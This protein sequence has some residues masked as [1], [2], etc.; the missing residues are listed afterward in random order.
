M[1]H[2]RFQQ[3]RTSDT[4][5]ILWVSADPGSGKSVLAKHLIDNVLPHGI[6]GSVICYFFFKDDFEDQRSAKSAIS[7]ILHQL[8]SERDDLFSDDVLD[9]FNNG[10]GY[11]NR[12]LHDLWDILVMALSQNHQS[13]KRSRDVICVVDGFDECESKGQSELAKILCNFYGGHADGAT[14][15]E[16][17][18]RLKF[19]ITSRPYDSIR[20]ILQPLLGNS[21]QRLIHLAGEGEVE[22]T[23]IAAEIVLFIRARIEQLTVLHRLSLDEKKL[24]LD[25]ILCVPNRT[26]LWVYLT[27]DLI[28]RNFHENM[29]LSSV[30]LHLP[31]TVDSAYERILAK[32]TDRATTKKLLHI[33]VAA[34]RPLTLKEMNVALAIRQDSK[35]YDGIRVVPEARFREYIRNLCGLFVTIIDSKIYLL[36]QT[37]KEFLVGSD[38][39][40]TIS[41]CIDANNNESPWKSSLQPQ[42]SHHVLLRIAIWYLCLPTLEDDTLSLQSK[43]HPFK[44]TESPFTRSCLTTVFPGYQKYDFEF[45]RY[46]ALRWLVH[47]YLSKRE[48]D[49]EYVPLLLHKNGPNSKYNAMWF[50]VYFSKHDYATAERFTNLAIVSYLGL[51]HFVQTE[52]EKS[53]VDVNATD[54]YYG[55]SALSWAS[56]RGHVDVVKLLLQLSQ[57]AQKTTRDN[58]KIVDINLKDGL[59]QTP[60]SL[61]AESGREEVMKLLLHA[62]ADV[63]VLDWIGET[64][65]SLSTTN[66]DVDIVRLLQQSGASDVQSDVQSEERYRASFKTA[67][68]WMTRRQKGWGK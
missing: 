42:D 52:F 28:E 37:A 4:S 67:I 34:M 26:Y 22:T 8:F 23:S 54:T 14:S 68:D 13:P 11:E 62:G 19:L 64:A 32:S 61:A 53:D 65:L 63:D 20:K 51:T 48:T 2:T 21:G 60:L 45:F 46:C 18:F 33:V 50:N 40:S 49:D 39:A 47:L 58:A 38:V 6:D 30:T 24:L 1:Q 35:T 25:R 36:H 57:T 15:R 16:S 17:H 41:P 29:D 56:K 5:S 55:R 9:R 7:C 3:W 31:E 10:G 12:S 59:G 43:R 66:G 27:L 44:I